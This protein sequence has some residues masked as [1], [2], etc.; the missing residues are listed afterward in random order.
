M[1]KSNYI[2]AFLQSYLWGYEKFYLQKDKWKLK[3]LK[4]IIKTM[5]TTHESMSTVQVS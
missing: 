1:L 4:T 2:S 5:V 3:S